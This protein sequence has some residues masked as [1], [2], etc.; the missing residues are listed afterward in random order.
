[1]ESKQSELELL[2]ANVT[3]IETTFLTFL[4]KNNVKTLFNN[5]K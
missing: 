3:E 4:C 2:Q 1:M 5:I